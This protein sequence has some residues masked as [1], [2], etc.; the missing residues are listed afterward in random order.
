[1]AVATDV[2]VGVAADME[3]SHLAAEALALITIA[4][5]W[6]WFPFEISIIIP[7]RFHS[8]KSFRL[9][10]TLMLNLQLVHLF[11]HAFVAYMH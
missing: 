11:M 3:Y 7:H 4:Q 5:M 1:M 8:I 9:L 2:A 6:R 10:A